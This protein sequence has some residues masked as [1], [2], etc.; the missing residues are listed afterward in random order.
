MLSEKITRVLFAAAVAAALASPAFAQGVW[1][2]K[3]VSPTNLYRALLPNEN[4]SRIS[5]LATRDFAQL[6]SEEITA[7][8][9][10][11]PY[12]NAQKT[13]IIKV[14]QTLGP[15]M[16]EKEM[17]YLLDK[18]TASYE[19]YY[20]AAMN[21]TVLDKQSL[22]KGTFSTTTVILGR[23]LYMSY[24]D[25]EWGKQTIKVSILLSPSTKFEQIAIGPEGTVTSPQGKMFFENFIFESGMTVTQNKMKDVWSAK[26]SPLHIFT[27]YEP[28]I[29]PPYLPEKPS[30]KSG[31]SFETVSFAFKDPVRDQTLLYNIY[32]YKTGG[33]RTAPEIKRFLM[34]K[35]VLKRRSKGNSIPF[36]DSP[37]KAT[38]P[39]I[40]ASYRIN[41]TVE[42]PYFNT[43][44]LKAT[45][46]KDFFVVQEILGSKKL[47]ESDFAKNLLDLL[48]FHPE[49]YA[50]SQSAAPQAI[51]PAPTPA[52]ASAPPASP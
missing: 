1:W 14:D 15:G 47:A 40:S 50:P 5:Y 44:L 38:P 19:D 20:T 33:A 25:P 23:D 21:G 11:R 48:V 51:K 13:F 12:K 32:A 16:S 36:K 46:G 10:Q 34:D 22:S 9:D 18:A 6:S 45:Y 3:Y 4:K 30:V 24:Q 43:S 17:N 42:F 29:A 7:V 26:E 35:F 8:I 27:Y 52:P 31:K 41:G 39:T 49:K 2:D 37:P 28:E